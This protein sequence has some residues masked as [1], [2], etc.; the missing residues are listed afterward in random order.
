MSQLEAH[1]AS[2]RQQ[3]VGVDATF[4]GPFGQRPIVYADWTASGR[5]YGPIE[6]LVAN[7]IGPFIGNTHTESSFTGT[8]MTR[9][10]HEARE[11]IKRHVNAGPEDALLLCGSGMTAAINKLQRI[12]GL[13]VP[14]YLRDF[15]DVP[16]EKR[17]I[18]FVTHM[19]HHSNHTTWLETIARVEVLPPDE[20]GLV[21]VDALRDALARHADHPYKIG[22]FT[23][24]SNVTGIETPYHELAR[25]MHEQGGVCIVD[26]AACAPYVEIDM[27]PADDP[28]ARLDAI[29][30]SP[31]K[32]LGGPGSSGV[33]VFN[34][35]LYNLEVPERPGGGTVNWTDPWNP[36]SYIDDIEVREDGGTPGFLQGIRAA[37]AMRL[38]EQMGGANIRA[39]EEELLEILFDA[40]PTVPG[41]HILADHIHQRLGIVSFYVDGL[42]YNLIVKLLNDRYGIQVRGGCSCAGTYGHY[43]LHIDPPRSARWRREVV[44][45]HDQS[46]KPGWVRLSIHPTMTDDE[47]RYCLDAIREVVAHGA[48]WGAEYD[49]SCATNEFA[50]PI[51]F[52]YA[53]R[54]KQWFDAEELAHA[55]TVVRET[56]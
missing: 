49:Y 35:S 50:H 8:I 51:A 5:Y 21:S 33:L 43:L 26:F 25:A 20:Q 16:E 39:R 30:F 10:Y 32:F 28:A 19:E 13:R 12:L 14:E 1:F 46:H 18:V 37:L 4:E 22:A 29:V 44:E 23:A 45:Q 42:H 52:D 3:I 55:T 41:L 11:I 2:F 31:H 7:E 54:L 53:D 36:H 27:H 40:L 17:P 6:R 47:L 48:E 15:T 9:A 56:S 38:K 24:C 34:A